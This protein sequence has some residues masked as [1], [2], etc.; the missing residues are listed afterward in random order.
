MHHDSEAFFLLDDGVHTNHGLM[1]YSWHQALRSGSIF[2]PESP[3]DYIFNQRREVWTHHYA[4]LYLPEMLEVHGKSSSVLHLFECSNQ[5]NATRHV[6]KLND[7]Y[8]SCLQHGH[9]IIHIPEDSLQT[10]DFKCEVH[11]YATY[12]NHT[13]RG[14]LNFYDGACND[15][16]NN[17]FTNDIRVVTWIGQTPPTANAEKHGYTYFAYIAHPPR[18]RYVRDHCDE[19]AYNYNAE[20]C[21]EAMRHSRTIL[22]YFEKGL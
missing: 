13:R 4:G 10:D 16:S 5:T 6:Y 12:R 7:F 20:K 19:L 18:I 8:V 15:S 3:P 17:T 1:I 22:T 2:L 11:N 21:E 9:L 14:N